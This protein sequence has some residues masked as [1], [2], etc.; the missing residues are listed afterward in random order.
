MIALQDYIANTYKGVDVMR[1]SEKLT[2][3]YLFSEDQRL[4][5]FECWPSDEDSA[6]DEDPDK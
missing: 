4:D 3:T 5:I 2:I 1:N 6:N